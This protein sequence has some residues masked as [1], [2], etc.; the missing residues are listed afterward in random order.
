MV[1]KIVL[2]AVCVVGVIGMIGVAA[3]LHLAVAFPVM[4]L[5][6]WLCPDLFHLP[7]ITYWQAVAL[8]VLLRLL[9]P[10]SFSMK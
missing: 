6:N 2:A 8:P 4:S 1:E 3:A 10:T 9:W 7:T 5:W